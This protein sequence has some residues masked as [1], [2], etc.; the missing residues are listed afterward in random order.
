MVFAAS[1]YNTGGG[2][3]KLEK[4]PNGITA[5]EVYFTKRMQ[6]HHGGVVLVGDYLYGFDQ[7]TLTCIDFKTGEVKWADRSVGKGSVTYADGLIFARAE[8]GPMAIVEATP[9]AYVVKGQFTPPDK[10]GGTTWPHPVV[11]AGHLY[12]RDQDQ[13]FC[14]DVKD[15]AAP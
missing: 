8:R 6:N 13:I 14:Y 3:A 10:L 2:L 11:T 12:L 5:T 4:G 15:P 1:G 9:T 7:G